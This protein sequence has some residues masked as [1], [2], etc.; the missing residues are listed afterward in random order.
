M[1]KTLFIALCL[2]GTAITS[3]AQLKVNSDGKV[4]IATNLNTSYT[5]LLV[6]NSTFGLGTSNVGIVGSKT[7]MEGKNNIGVLGTTIANSSFSNDKNYGVLG[8][9]NYMNATHGKNYGL[10][11]MIGFT[12]AH[13]GG[14][15]VYG[16][17]YTYYF[18]F[19]TNI[20]GDYAGYFAGAVKVTGNIT[21]QNVFIPS[22]SRL[23]ENVMSLNERGG[24]TCT[25]DN[26][27]AMNVIEYN[28]KSRISNE[29]PDGI[30]EDETGKKREA[31]EYLKRDE[32]KMCARR[33][34]GIDAEELR[35]V[36]PDL[37]LEGQDGY[38]SVNYVELVPLLI[39]SIQELKAELDELKGKDFVD[40]GADP[41]SARDDMA[42]ACASQNDMTAID[43]RLT[44]GE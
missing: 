36:Y 28:M 12:G 19:P 14:A 20:Q 29:L 8:V 17:N 4:T 15:G 7:A 40:G 5:N 24:E 10:C 34:F 13:Y 31:F 38:L 41:V 44:P 1:K 32:M 6:G 33:H 9:V 16:T 43:K 2:L 26:L 23:S 18:D 11:G 21:T 3:N 22:D 42:A 37:V 35:K 39:R 25:L 30:E 27:L